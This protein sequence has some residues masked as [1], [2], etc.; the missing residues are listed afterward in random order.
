MRTH[1]H[2]HAQ[3]HTHTDAHTDFLPVCIDSIRHV[4]AVYIFSQVKNSK[5]V[6]LQNRKKWDLEQQT[7]NLFMGGQTPLLTTGTDHA[8]VAHS[9]YT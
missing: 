4:K 8:F 2:T 5:K 1:T 6:R 3:T 7:D 9:L